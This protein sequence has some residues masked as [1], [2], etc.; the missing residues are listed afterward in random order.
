MTLT[1]YFEDPFWIGLFEHYNGNLYGVAKIIFGS[2]PK[3][4]EIQLLILK[5]FANV[6]FSYTNESP[7]RTALK[8]SNPKRMQRMIN[9]QLQKKETSTKSQIALQMQK[10]EGKERRKQK[11]KIAKIEEANRK[12]ELRKQKKKNKHKGK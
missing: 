2:E 11:S 12:Y 5:H 7:S 3:N 1:V 4:Q 8:V 6:K 9:R 10:Q